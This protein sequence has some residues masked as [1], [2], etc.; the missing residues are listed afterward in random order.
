MPKVKGKC[1]ACGMPLELGVPE[2]LAGAE[3]AGALC[4]ACTDLQFL[5]SG[6]A[7]VEMRHELDGA[8]FA[9]GKVTIT[10]GAIEALAEASEHA[11]S[12][13]SSHARG[14]WGENGNFD[15]IEL[16]GDERCRG[17]EATED[18]CKINKSNVLAR[19]DRVMSE[20]TTGLGRRLWI[21]TILD[22]GGEVHA[23]FCSC[24]AVAARAPS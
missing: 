22:V 13:L 14:D 15:E 4:S 1:S 2:P 17:W 21:I 12:F 23:G 16:T 19:R 20:Y 6:G 7:I 8:R 10:G 24:R 11:A 3:L 9:L 18:S 5:K